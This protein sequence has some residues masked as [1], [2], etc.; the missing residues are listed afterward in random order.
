MT[1]S[2]EPITTTSD[3]GNGR[4]AS[5]RQPRVTGGPGV[6]ATRAGA[7]GDNKQKQAHARQRIR[8]GQDVEIHVTAGRNQG[9]GGRQGKEASRN[10]RARGKQRVWGRGEA[11]VAEPRGERD[12]GHPADAAR[13]VL[14]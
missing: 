7:A 8:R 9:S 6:G 11:G 2:W 1:N 10:A 5:A 13:E 3:A 14:E 4:A 12:D